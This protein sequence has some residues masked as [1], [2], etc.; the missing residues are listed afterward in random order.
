MRISTCAPMRGEKKLGNSR[1]QLGNVFIIFPLR[2]LLSMLRMMNPG[3][4]I[5][6][7]FGWGLGLRSGQ[8]KRPS[9]IDFLFI[10]S[11]HFHLLWCWMLF[12]FSFIYFVCNF[13][14]FRLKLKA[15]YMYAAGFYS[16][17]IFALIF[18]ETRRSDFGVS[19]SHHVATVILIVLS[20]IFRYLFI[21]VFF[22]TSNLIAFIY[23]VYLS[24]LYWLQFKLLTR[25]CS[26]FICF[27]RLLWLIIFINL[28][29]LKGKQTVK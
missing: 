25:R 11:Y 27:V 28:V 8:I 14:H 1:N 13:Y 17:S 3:L 26:F 12:F 10:S 21:Q 6:E 24:S 4:P 15:V 29:R 19:M 7:T 9:M 23:F 20:Y 5:R 18:W 22:F 2:F 16:Y